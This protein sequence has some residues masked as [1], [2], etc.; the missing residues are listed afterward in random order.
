MALLLLLAGTPLRAEE[1]DESLTPE[2]PPPLVL[3]HVIERVD[4]V[5]FYRALDFGPPG[6]ACYP[7][8]TP[9][10]MKCPLLCYQQMPSLSLV[11]AAAV[12]GISIGPFDRRARGRLLEELLASDSVHFA[13]AAGEESLTASRIAS[14]AGT[15][16]EHYAIDIEGLP[17]FKNTLVRASTA[18]EQFTLKIGPQLY[19]VP[20]SPKVRDGFYRLLRQCPD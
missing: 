3:D 9:Q 10:H 13:T 15:E 8:L 5:E 16:D 20:L 7:C 1:P 14:S 17:G 6:S 12:R 19:I 11:C 18:T 4:R 2:P